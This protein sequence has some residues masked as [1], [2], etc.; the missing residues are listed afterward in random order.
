MYLVDKANSKDLDE[1]SFALNEKKF[2]LNLLFDNAAQALQECADLNNLEGD[3]DN[4]YRVQSALGLGAQQWL[5]SLR[6]V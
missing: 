1:S 2:K 4:P 5:D 6:G 3:A